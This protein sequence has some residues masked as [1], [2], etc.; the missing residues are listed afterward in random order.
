MSNIKYWLKKAGIA[1][2]L[3]V[4]M[5]FCSSIFYQTGSAA[6]ERHIAEFEW[7]AMSDD[8]TSVYYEGSDEANDVNLKDKADSGEAADSKEATGEE[9]DA[10]EVGKGTSLLSYSKISAEEEEDD[11]L[12]AFSSDDWELILVNKQHPIPDDY[13]F[14]L[15]SIHN[16]LRVDKRITDKLDAMLS[17]AADDGVPLLVISPYRNGDKQK[18]LFD[19]K[20]KRALKNEKS[21]L[22]AYRETAQAVTIP[23]SSEHEI[24]LAA[25]LTT[26]A[27]ITLDAEY[28]ESEGGKW[29]AANC[30]R[31]G[32]I[33]RYPVGKEK[34][35]G[36]EYEPWHFR[37]VG[38][39][40][41]EYIT[42]HDL[43]LEEFVSLL[44]ERERAMEQEKSE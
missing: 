36:I 23:G 14:E 18:D 31:F 44:K 8:W 34:I 19:K 26:K 3:I 21:Y 2:L 41:A 20:V 37:Y 22:D 13:S 39:E 38:R 6:D 35:T 16:G 15:G 5:L 28:A 17:A 30:T 29:L 4:V 1:A 27:H 32:F 40:A 25:D 24:G 12:A 42:E 11:P 7:E 9:I 43:S 10:S 33:L